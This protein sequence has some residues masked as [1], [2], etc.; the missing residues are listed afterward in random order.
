VALAV[1]SS[2]TQTA[3]VTT[4]HTLAAPSTNKTRVLRVDLGAMVAGDTVELRI[5][6]AVL[7]GGT[8]REQQN[9]TYANVVGSPIFESIPISSNQ[10]ATFTLKQTTGT[11]RAYPWAV[12]T[13]D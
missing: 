5:K 8:V 12:L 1:E 9:W 3:T 11:G 4:E 10:G 13:L 7:S 6:T 2:G